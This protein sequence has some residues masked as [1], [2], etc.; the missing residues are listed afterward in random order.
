MTRVPV[1]AA[2][3][4]GW[5]QIL[6][7]FLAVS[8]DATGSLTSAAVTAAIGGVQS[9]LNVK[10]Q[11]A[12][13][14]NNVADD[15]VAVQA[16]LD[17]ADAASPRRALFFPAGTYLVGTL[18]YR[19]Q[20]L[21]GEGKNLTN[22][23][24]KPSQDVF[25]ADGTLGQLAR[26]QTRICDLTITVDDSVNASAS[27]PNRGGVG[28]ACFA[29]EFNN[30]ALAAPLRWNAASI[31][32]VIVQSLSGTAKN[33]SC[34]FYLQSPP[35][36]SRFKDIKIYRLEFGW[37]E[38]YPTLNL[39][40]VEF[41]SDHNDYDDI[42]TNGCINGFRG[43]N[44][45]NSVMSNLVMHGSATNGLELSGVQSQARAACSFVDIR[46]VMIEQ[47]SGVPWNVQG[48]GMNA[49]TVS[50]GGTQTIV[51]IAADD[52]RCDGW[53]I[54]NAATAPPALRITGS[55]NLVRGLRVTGAGSAVAN[56]YDYVDDQGRGNVVTA[57]AL[58][59]NS[60]NRLQQ[61][62][63]RD[64][65]V[66]HDRDT[67]ALLMGYTD[68][69]VSGKDLLVNPL[70]IIPVGAVE[71][72]DF[73]YVADTATDLGVRLRLLTASGSFFVQENQLAGERAFR[74]GTFLPAGKIRVYVKAKLATGGT[75]LWDL[76]ASSVSAG[77][78]TLTWTN[79]YTVQSWDIDLTGKTSANPLEIDVSAVGGG[80]VIPLD[81]QW[82]MFRPYQAD[83]LVKGVSTLGAALIEKRIVLVYSATI[84][85]D[86]S[87]GN[88]FDITATNATAFTIS[89]PTSP[90]NDQ[91]ITYTIRN[92]SG[93]ALGAITWG[94]AF[95]LSAWTSPATANSRSITFRYDGTNW[96]EIGRTPAD[97]PN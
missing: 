26:E 51:T 32:R 7:D 5:G 85:T 92:T 44:W 94:A 81:I 63:T 17:A 49:S 40:S 38:H 80:G 25:K 96:V 76:T 16:A 83:L 95:K 43:I 10:T 78:A 55:R 23:L 74:V 90:A 64:G 71:N 29:F 91:R 15:T 50:I 53:T 9:A 57:A 31:E 1:V 6:N 60:R 45:A 42:Y 62:L 2:D 46:G 79:A 84:A 14:G 89:N 36:L 41:Y 18:N 68:P 86:A 8:H 66:L 12:A 52:S 59:S 58:Y 73:S 24:G 70:T 72:T 87:L 47:H 61:S 27:F 93:G 67:A 35:N 11:Y 39:T 20:S 75:Q 34:G 48:V 88:M 37:W 56:A 69:F 21:I 97:V 4:D 65:R 3:V 13:V 22:I 77:S 28:N 30:G 54:A 19:G 33:K 82:M